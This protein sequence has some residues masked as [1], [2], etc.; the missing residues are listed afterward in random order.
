MSGSAKRCSILSEIQEYFNIEQKKI[1][2]LSS[3]RWLSR[4]ACVVRILENYS[5]LQHYFQLAVVEDKLLSA[6]NILN[7]LNNLCNKAYLYFLKYALNIFNSFNALFQ[8]RLPQ[9]HVLFK[10]SHSLMRQL[11]QNFMKREVIMDK[12]LASI[13]I[14]NPH[15]FVDI[16]KVYLGN[17]CEELLTQL[18]REAVHDIR[19]KCLNFY[20]MSAVQI[21]KRLP[22]NNEIFKHMSFLSLNCDEEVNVRNVAEQFKNCIDVDAC[23]VEFRN[24]LVLDKTFMTKLHNMPVEERWHEISRLKTFNDSCEFKHIARLAKLVLTL[25]HSNAESERIF[26]IVTDVKVKKRNR[27][28]SE[29]LNSVC[30]IRSML[31][32]NNICCYEYSFNPGH[33]KLW[34]SKAMYS[35]K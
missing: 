23:E 30:M 8:S 31:Q 12:N 28:G 10:K 18:P 6:E 13:N 21:Q 7:Q 4:Q 35:F 22:L 9:I 33:K 19:L 11:C 20:I 17:E 2:K 27:I 1:L 16:N 34:N 24:L 14:Q 5:V 26:S 29:T 32:S 25:P 15:N 3:T